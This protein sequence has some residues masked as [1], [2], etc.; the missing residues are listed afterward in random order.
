MR[1][2]SKTG[3]D[4]MAGAVT[5][6]TLYKKNA[7]DALDC[8]DFWDALPPDKL[9]R[10]C[11]HALWQAYTITRNELEERGSEYVKFGTSI[12]FTSI[13]ILSISL[14]I[15]LSIVSIL[16]RLASAKFAVQKWG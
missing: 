6:H 16:L 10:K 12:D 8:I 3:V 11:K 4:R 15:F 14:L 1:N 9:R 5:R 7:V 13:S 2:F